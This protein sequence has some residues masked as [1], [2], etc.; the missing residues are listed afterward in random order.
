VKVLIERAERGADDKEDKRVRYK[1][2]DKTSQMM[3]KEE[4][5]KPLQLN[6]SFPECSPCDERAGRADDEEMNKNDFLIISNQFCQ[7][8]YPLQRQRMFDKYLSQ[9]SDIL[10]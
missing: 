4:L 6:N 8:L 3:N 10:R 1:Q 7:Y 9:F 5:I 2:N